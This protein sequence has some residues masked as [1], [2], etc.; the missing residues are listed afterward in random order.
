[1]KPNETIIQEGNKLQYSGT[2][3]DKSLYFL[4]ITKI[5]CLGKVKDF[6]GVMSEANKRLENDAK[7]K[8]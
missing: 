2:C 1:M 5:L 4:K 7:V 3:P 8:T 6:L